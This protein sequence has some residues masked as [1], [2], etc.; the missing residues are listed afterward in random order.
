[1]AL[2]TV[3]TGG[4]LSVKKNSKIV[5]KQSDQIQTCI[6]LEWKSYTGWDSS[7]QQLRKFHRLYAFAMLVHCFDHRTTEAND[8][9]M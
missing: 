8:R 1:M 3:T 2:V 5:S 7:Q 6:K 9:T 4:V